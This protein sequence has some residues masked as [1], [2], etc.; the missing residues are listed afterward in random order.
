LSFCW[1][2]HLK[3]AWKRQYEEISCATWNWKTQGK[4]IMVHWYLNFRERKSWLGN[5][6]NFFKNSIC[7]NF[8]QF[9]LI[10]HGADISQFTMNRIQYVNV[11]FILFN[12]FAKITLDIMIVINR[13]KEIKGFLKLPLSTQ[14]NLNAL[15]HHRKL[16]HTIWWT[17]KRSNEP[18]KFYVT[19]KIKSFWITLD[20]IT[21]IYIFTHF[22]KGSKKMWN[23]FPKPYQK[24][25]LK[26]QTSV[27]HGYT[28]K[29]LHIL[30]GA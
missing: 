5:E 29:K 15:W 23:S 3:R 16:Q 13:L 7:C 25:K 30:S 11:S 8:G 10:I 28:Y 27:D 2:L 17:S 24:Y 22:F 4:Y 21:V 12:V 9:T 1:N 19:S 20:N 26:D 18:I 14:Q 6:A